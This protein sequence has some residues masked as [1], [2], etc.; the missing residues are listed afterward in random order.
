MRVYASVV[1]SV[2]GLCVLICGICAHAQA[3]QSNAPTF[4]ESYESAFAKA[5]QECTALWSD[6]AFDPLRSKIPLGGDKPTFSMLT[7]TQKLQPKDK[8]LADLA[9]K[10]L[11]KCRAA[12]APVYA[13]LPPQVSN[14]INGV[15]RRQDDFIARLYNG[16]ITFG[17]Y[18]VGMNELTGK[19]TEAISG[20]PS[21]P[22]SASA[23]SQPTP[24]PV[25]QVRAPVAPPVATFNGKRLALVIGN[26]NYAKLPKLSNP[27]NDAR[28]IAEVLQK[29][30][31]STQL[32]LD[33]SQ[34]SIR[35]RSANSPVS[36]KRPMWRS[37]IMPDT[38]H[39]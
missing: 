33:A 4:N 22:K 5:R 19:L 9:I 15:E 20:I 39:N 24:A 31:Y 16:Q 23:I 36:Q 10:T 28:S 34:D 6:R 21:Q 2:M 12:Y 3:Q 1:T 30:G 18:N 29:M 27:T 37:Y 8:P 11:E 25:A 38:A 14:M 32:V 26:S 13:M 17:E 7:N 35:L